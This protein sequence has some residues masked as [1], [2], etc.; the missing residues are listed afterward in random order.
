[1]FI[2]DNAAIGAGRNYFAGAEVGLAFQRKTDEFLQFLRNKKLVE[3]DTLR[4]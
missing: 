1:M 3:N 4:R 2:V